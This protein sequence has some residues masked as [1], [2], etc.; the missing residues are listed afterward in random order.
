MSGLENTYPFIKGM[1]EQE[2]ATWLMA[3][4]LTNCFGSAY[5]RK[6]GKNTMLIEQRP[7]FV[8]WAENTNFTSVDEYP[9]P[10]VFMAHADTYNRHKPVC[11]YILNHP[12]THFIR[13]HAFTRDHWERRK[14][15]NSIGQKYVGLWVP[16][17]LCECYPLGSVPKWKGSRPTKSKND[18]T[19]KETTNN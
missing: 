4:H 7:A 12:M 1:T 5:L 8:R 16:K 3:Q 6:A 9:Q 17:S 18:T 19:S 14:H 13:A 11:L 15:T 2:V 10:S